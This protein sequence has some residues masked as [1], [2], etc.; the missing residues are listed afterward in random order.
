MICYWDI[1]VI[2]IQAKEIHYFDSM[3]GSGKK[4]LDAMLQYIVDEGREKKK[5]VINT[6]EWSLISQHQNT[7]QQSNGFD[8]GVFTI[9]C[10]DFLSDD[11][12]IE[13]SSYSQ[14]D[15]PYF[16]QKILVDILRGELNYP[17]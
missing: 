3:S 9:V 8:C 16:R 4:Y 10:A 17:I 7:P 14:S 6:S 12:S 5:I 15:M 11:L 1:G 2:D 13:S